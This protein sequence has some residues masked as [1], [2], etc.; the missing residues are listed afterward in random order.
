MFPDGFAFNAGL[1]LALHNRWFSGNNNTY[2]K[3]LGFGDSFI[4]ESAVDFALPIKADVFR[5][6]MGEHV[7]RAWPRSGSCAYPRSS[8]PTIVP[9]RN[10]H[11]SSS[12][13]TRGP[14]PPPYPRPYPTRLATPTDDLSLA[15][16]RVRKQ[17]RP[18]RG[19]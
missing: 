12:P 16:F 15:L 4:V 14:R 19:A 17:A 10:P 11:A 18:R 1:P 9:L 3:K 8:S 2:I 7:C 5:Y 6:L 13:R